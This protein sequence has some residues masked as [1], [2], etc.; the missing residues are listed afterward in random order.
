[1]KVNINFARAVCYVKCLNE[2]V[3]VIFVE[4]DMIGKMKMENLKVAKA[5]NYS[6]LTDGMNLST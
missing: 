4:V 5:R 6:V 1:M 2:R 3:T